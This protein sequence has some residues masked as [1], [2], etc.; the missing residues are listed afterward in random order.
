MENRFAHALTLAYPSPFDPLPC[1]NRSRVF[2]CLVLL[3]LHDRARGVD[4]SSALLPL[5]WTVVHAMDERS[6][7]QGATAASLAASDTEIIAVLD[8]TDEASFS[9]ARP[10]SS[11]SRFVAHT[12]ARLCGLTVQGCSEQL[13]ARWS[14]TYRGTS[15]LCVC[16][17]ASVRVW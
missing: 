5:P 3:L 17:R 1:C 16:A 6:P 12:R 13:Q 11:S 8:G 4:F 15:T 14:Y 10:F 9:L 2:S 7:L